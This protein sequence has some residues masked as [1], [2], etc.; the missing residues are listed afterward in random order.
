MNPKQTSFSGTEK[1]Y[2]FLH[3]LA[4]IFVWTG[5]F[6]VSWK[7]MIPVYVLVTIQ[8]IIFKSCLMNKRHGLDESDDH[9]FYSEV[10]ELMGFQP[11]RKMLKFFVRKVLNIFL[12]IMTLLWQLVLG[13]NP[14]LF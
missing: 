2:F 9:T 8:F 11:D 10:F 1:F 13:N 3:F 14:L 4:V 6:L 12:T 7:I 5:P